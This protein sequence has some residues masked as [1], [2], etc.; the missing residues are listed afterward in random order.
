MTRNDLIRKVSQRTEINKSDCEEVLDAMAI[1]IMNS[2]IDGEKVF[3]K[4]F[5]T[6]EITQRPER[7]GRNPRTGNTETYPPVKSIKCRISQSFKDAVNG[8]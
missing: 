4:N 8:K 3:L 1:E 6:F 7:Q 5:I 2:L